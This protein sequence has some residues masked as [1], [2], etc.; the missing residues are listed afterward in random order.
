MVQNPDYV[1]G[2]FEV[3]HWLSHTGVTFLGSPVG[4]ISK[5]MGAAIHYEVCSEMDSEHGK[6]KPL[7]IH[8]LDSFLYYWELEFCPEVTNGIRN[9][10]K[11]SSRPDQNS[12]VKIWIQMWEK[13]RLVSTSASR[14]GPSN[15]FRFYRL[16]IFPIVERA[17]PLKFCSLTPK[18]VK[19]IY[20]WSL[21]SSHLHVETTPPPS[22]EQ[23]SRKN[24]L[25]KG[26]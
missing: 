6:G 8:G 16:C 21:V 11:D 19:Q 5:Y 14:T 1:G 12:F 18:S 2:R 10:R 3:L 4:S 15:R 24:K 17:Q 13:A 26:F 22:T 25:W 23:G 7:G 20:S 9:G